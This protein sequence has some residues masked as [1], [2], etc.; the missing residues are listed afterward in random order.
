MALL[1]FKPAG[2]TPLAHD[3]EPRVRHGVAIA[4]SEIPNWAVEAK[5]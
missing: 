1:R 4:R 5:K 3:G 2:R